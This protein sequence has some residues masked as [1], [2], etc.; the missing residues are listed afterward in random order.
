MISI[1]KISYSTIIA[2]NDWAASTFASINK[3][4]LIESIILVDVSFWKA[5]KY[6]LSCVVPIF[7]V[8]RL[9]DSDVKP[10]MGYIYTY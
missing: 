10:T 2:S 5:I 1:V 4:N 7:N 3:R 6:Y 9:M 8:L